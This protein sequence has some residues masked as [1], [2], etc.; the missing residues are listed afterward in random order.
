MSSKNLKLAAAMIAI[1]MMSF[2]AGT[3]AQGRYPYINQAE[4][5]LQSALST[6][7]SG[8]SVFG[9]HKVAAERDISA[10]LNEL[11]AAKQ[12]AFSRGM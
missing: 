2:A 9:G 7:H 11:Q 6:L 12:F 8:R 1:G 10:A 4:G 3:F 5:A